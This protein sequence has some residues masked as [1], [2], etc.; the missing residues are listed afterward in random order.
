[1]LSILGSEDGTDCMEFAA[2]PGLRAGFTRTH[3]SK[4]NKLRGEG[5]IRLE[6]GRHSPLFIWVDT[7]VICLDGHDLVHDGKCWSSTVQRSTFNVQ[8]EHGVSV[9]CIVLCLS[10]PFSV[11]FFY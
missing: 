4:K 3:M 9:V 11:Y 7:P 6:R 1:M 5:E 10:P 2:V 8:H